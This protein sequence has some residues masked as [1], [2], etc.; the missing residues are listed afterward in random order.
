V[1]YLWETLYYL[2]WFLYLAPTTLTVTWIF[3][4]APPHSMLMIMPHH[5]IPHSTTTRHHH[6][7]PH[8]NPPPPRSTSFYANDDVPPPHSTTTKIRVERPLYHYYGLCVAFHRADDLWKIG[9]LQISPP[10]T[11]WTV[12]ITGV[13]NAK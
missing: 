8:S 5:H 12:F 6:T 1:L 3:N 7:P 2:L 13:D 11:A 9:L 10:C 4:D